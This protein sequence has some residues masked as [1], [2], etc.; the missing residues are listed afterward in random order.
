MSSENIRHLTYYHVLAMLAVGGLSK[1]VVL[2]TVGNL[3]S[4][5]LGGE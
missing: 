5:R 1:D 4:G 2:E 3:G